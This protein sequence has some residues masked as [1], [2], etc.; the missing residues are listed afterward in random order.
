MVLI[1]RKNVKPENLTL[2]MLFSSSP[3]KFLMSL[4]KLEA[5]EQ[6]SSWS[7]KQFFSSLQ[8]FSYG[9]MCAYFAGVSASVLA[10]TLGPV[11]NFLS[12]VLGCVL[13][14]NRKAVPGKS[15]IEWPAGLSHQGFEEIIFSKVPSQELSFPSGKIAALP[16]C[17][18][19]TWPPLVDA[20]LSGGEQWKIVLQAG[21]AADKINSLRERLS[22]S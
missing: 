9:K 6:K 15:S 3:R 12:G 8:E 1:I 22:A 4:H 13:F 17:L 10:K 18:R 7:I 5:E 16:A 20:L 14:L 19:C 11:H 2:N 21:T